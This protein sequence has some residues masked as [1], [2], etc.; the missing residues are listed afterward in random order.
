MATH[1]SGGQSGRKKV[2]VWMVLLSVNLFKR[3]T[4]KQVQYAVIALFTF[5][6]GWMQSTSVSFEVNQFVSVRWF[7]VAAVEEY[8]HLILFLQ[9]ILSCY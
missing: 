2:Q 9:E 1:K 4:R 5:I 6:Y 8:S 3:H 7:F